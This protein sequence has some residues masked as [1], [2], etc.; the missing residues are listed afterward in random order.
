MSEHRH[1]E[2]IMDYLSGNLDQA[3]QKEFEAKV[4]SGEIAAT[5]V[6]AA[7]AAFN[8][9]YALPEPEPGPGLEAKFRQLLDTEKQKVR[10]VGPAFAWGDLWRQ[11]NILLSPAKFAYSLV[12]FFAGFLVA[13]LAFA[14]KQQSREHDLEVKML[15]AELSQMKQ[16][17][18]TTLIEQP[19]AVDRLKAVNISREMTNA[20]ERVIGALFHSLNNDP[21]VNVRLAAVEA[22]KKHTASPAVRTGLIK[23]INQQD[24]PMVQI[25]LAELMEALQEKNAVPQL[26]R[27]LENEETNE[28][29]KDKIKESINV[30]I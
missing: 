12:I 3:Q 29:V 30:L 2:L 1:E 10:P 24:S 9:F 25:A 23:S 14:P 7:Q 15:A 17:L 11:L 6:A 18:F 26:E 13:W 20:D 8:A 5:E 28:L 22:L 21:N 4:A 16:V 27:L 19:L